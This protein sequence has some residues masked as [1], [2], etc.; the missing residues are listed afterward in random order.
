MTNETIFELDDLPNSVGV[1]GAGPLGL[2][3]AQAL[4]RLGVEIMLFDQGDKLGGLPEGD[5]AKSLR[6]ALDRELTV[7]LG[8]TL[9]A[10]ADDSGV[11]LTW[12]GSSSGAMHFNYLLVAAGRSPRLHGL[13]LQNTG[14]ALD[15]YGLPKVNE[16]TLQCGDAPIFIAGDADHS[17]PVLHEATATGA[18]AG[19]NAA[20]YPEV[21][22][23]RRFTP[24]AITFTDPPVAIVG[25]TPKPN[26]K[27]VV[28]GVV[29]Y[30]NEGR[31]KIE[32]KT[33][34]CIQIFAERETGR[35]TGA[36]MVGPGV[37]HTAHL[38]AWSIQQGLT[39]S[40]MLEMPFHHPTVEE[41]LKAALLEIVRQ[42]IA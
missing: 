12:L 3:M 23:S 38:I 29:A 39:A 11:R 30:A 4:A 8:V 25:D 15:E 42:L 33:A 34:G 24:L 18:I 40:K 7:R 16:H 27:A 19:H 5:P 2:E 26:D 41:G 1:V 31:A 37:D 35:L 21:T 28:A 13:C 20:R 22:P 32:A 17:R 14:L 36:V 6:E 9:A 10:K